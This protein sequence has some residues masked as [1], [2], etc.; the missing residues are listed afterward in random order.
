M[1]DLSSICAFALY[2]IEKDI[3]LIGRDHI[4]IIPLYQGWDKNGTYYV[5]SELKAL[6]GQ[7][8]KIEEFL[9][10]QYYYSPDGK[11]TQRTYRDWV[12]WIS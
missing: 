12:E 10:G 7:C 5:A 11:P 4:G 9:P 1:E 3:Y 2:D 6:E 8:S